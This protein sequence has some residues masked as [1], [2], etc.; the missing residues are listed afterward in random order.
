MDVEEERIATPQL[1]ECE[2]RETE[3]KKRKR[4]NSEML[5]A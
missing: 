1:V 2:S 4:H 5:S 3:E